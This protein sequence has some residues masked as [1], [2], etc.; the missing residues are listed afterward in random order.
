MVNIIKTLFHLITNILKSYVNHE[1]KMAR[2]KK[3]KRLLK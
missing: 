1:E 3:L 2:K